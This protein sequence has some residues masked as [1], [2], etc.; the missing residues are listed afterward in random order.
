MSQDIRSFFGVVPTKTPAPPTQNKNK[1]KSKTASKTSSKRVRTPVHPSPTKTQQPRTR[2]SPRKRNTTPTQSTRKSTSS[3]PPSSAI[4]VISDDEEEKVAPVRHSPRAKKRGRSPTTSPVKPPTA[5]KPRLDNTFQSSTK[6]KPLAR[7][8]SLTSSGKKPKRATAFNMEI[9]S[10]D[11]GYNPYGVSPTKPSNVPKAVPKPRQSIAKKAPTRTRAKAKAS[12]PI[13]AFAKQKQEADDARAIAAKYSPSAGFRAPKAVPQNLGLIPLPKGAPKSL[14]GAVFCL[15]GAMDSVTREDATALIE[16]LG[17]TCMKSVGVKLTHLIIGEGYGASKFAKAVSKGMVVMDEE[18]L[19][20]AI[21]AT[22]PELNKGSQV[23]PAAVSVP[24]D[25]P[26]VVPATAASAS[27]SLWTDKYAPTT[28]ASLIGNHGPIKMVR[29]YLRNF[30]KPSVGASKGKK[31]EKRALLLSGMPGIGMS[32]SAT[33]LAKEMGY[34]VIQLNASDV[35]NKSSLEQLLKMSMN[36]GIT[37]F[38]KS[39]SQALKKK[40]MLIMDEVDGMSSGDR[41]GIAELCSILPSSKIPIICIC[42]DREHPKLRPLAKHCHDVKFARPTTHQMTQRMAAIAA[43]EG[44]EISPTLLGKLLDSCHG[45]LRQALNLLQMWRTTSETLNDETVEAGLKKSGKSLNLGAN[46]I[47][48]EM[49]PWNPR[50][51]TVTEKIDMYFMDYSLLPILMHEAYLASGPTIAN[52]SLCADSISEGD[53]FTQAIRSRQMHSLMPAEALLGVIRPGALAGPT[54]PFL[55]F[56]QFLG[57]MSS[58]IRHVREL[59]NLAHDVQR[60]THA[61]P[62]SL[63]LEYNSMF[64]RK[65]SQPLAMRG[66]DGIDSVKSFME[67]YGISREDR[68]NVIE[69]ISKLGYEAK[70]PT[71]VKTLFTRTFNKAHFEFKKVSSKGETKEI[72]VAKTK[73]K[74][75]K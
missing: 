7:S 37:S 75:K 23:T 22:A 66:A 36:T 47:V 39:G 4:T 65:L 33:I 73:R 5:K 49:F 67:N 8:T 10:D 15:T 62:S 63:A 26:K 68:D 69:N 16:S 48:P 74:K 34:D 56:P 38:F 31:V 9:S 52:M 28:S 21:R 72:A 20:A 57:R 3:P 60:V 50:K 70:I 41:G 35:R 32:S 64:A 54:K 19:F 11:T 13:S 42:N 24:L 51:L 12:G 43:A 14:A 58:T 55:R 53:V 46:E 25:L 18:A 59:N 61:G 45:D 27:A 1:T 6:A 44:F 40:S 17:G 71:A 30:K 29:D 2:Q